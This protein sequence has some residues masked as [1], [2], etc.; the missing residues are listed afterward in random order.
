MNKLLGSIIYLVIW[1]YL[2]ALAFRYATIWSFNTDPGIKG[3]LLY[4][5]I[6]YIGFVIIIGSVLNAAAAKKRQ[7]SE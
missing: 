3:P 1:F 5:V 6:A 2:N 4:M 7:A